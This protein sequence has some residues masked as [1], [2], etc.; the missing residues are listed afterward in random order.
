[1]FVVID[2]L[3]DATFWCSVYDFGPKNKVKVEENGKKN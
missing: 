2:G 1:M 3:L